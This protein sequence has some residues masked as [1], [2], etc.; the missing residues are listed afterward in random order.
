[1]I[2]SEPIRDIGSGLLG[3]LIGEELERI[4]RGLLLRKV[5]SGCQ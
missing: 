5:G 1:V 3:M 2:S 4:D